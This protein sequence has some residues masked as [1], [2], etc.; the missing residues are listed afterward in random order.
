MLDST[1]EEV[2]FVGVP[3]LK[4]NQE[5][6]AK[7][8]YSDRGSK[9]RVIESGSDNFILQFEEPKIA[10]TPGQSVVLYDDSGML[11]AGGVISKLN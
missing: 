6:I 9:A 8:R 3:G 7:I 1:A 4:E 11:L 10:I 5:V 2:N